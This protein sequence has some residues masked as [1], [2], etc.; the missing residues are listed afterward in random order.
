LFSVT[1]ISSTLAKSWLSFSF[2]VLMALPSQTLSTLN[3]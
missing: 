2:S 3:A 1:E